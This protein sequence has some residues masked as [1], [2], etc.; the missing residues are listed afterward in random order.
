MAKSG[1]VT[2][3]GEGGATFSEGAGL[4]DMASDA[5]TT[6]VSTTRAPVGYTALLQR[7]TLLVG[8]NLIGV[9]SASGRLGVGV[10]GKNMY[11]GR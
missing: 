11:F 1:I 6:L 2:I 4:I 10:A 8:G 3:D 5:L 7:A 9:H